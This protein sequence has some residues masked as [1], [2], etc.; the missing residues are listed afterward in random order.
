MKNS[1]VDKQALEISVVIPVHNEQ[2]NIPEL[3]E[4]LIN[5]LEGMCESEGFTKNCFEI[6]MVDDGSKD[7]SW[8]LIQQIHSKD[9]RLKGLKFSRNFGHHFAITAGLDFSKGNSVVLMDGDLQDKPEEIV[10][11][12]DKFKEGYDLVYGIRNNRQDNPAKKVFAALF[13]W[14]INKVSEVKMPENQTMLRILRRGMVDSLKEMKE[15]L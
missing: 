9:N 11:V 5:V 12:Y 1:Q 7:E 8:K 15:Y 14:S 13:W 4:R 2:E 10:K 6:I 3:F